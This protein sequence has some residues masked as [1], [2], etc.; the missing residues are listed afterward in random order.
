[1]LYETME[2]EPL[3]RL[4][5]NKLVSTRSPF[6]PPLLLYSLFFFHACFSNQNSLANNPIFSFFFRALFW[7]CVLLNI[8]IVFAESQ[9]HR[10][11]H[12]RLVQGHHSGHPHACSS[13]QRVDRARRCSQRCG[14]G[15]ALTH[16]SLHLQVGSCVVLY[17]AA[18]LFI[19]LFVCV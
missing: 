19:L 7:M 4:A 8:F 6:L 12:G 2:L 9:L 11:H 3:M 17:L 1:M 10:D 18:A 5:W 16:S 13:R 14:L 15:S